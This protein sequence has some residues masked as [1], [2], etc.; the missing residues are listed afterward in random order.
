MF[1]LALF[2]LLPAAVLSD[3]CYPQ[4][5]YESDGYDY[6]SCDQEF[7]TCVP[8]TWLTYASCVYTG[9]ADPTGA[10]YCDDYNME[11][12]DYDWDTGYPVCHEPMHDGSDWS[13]WSDIA[14]NSWGWE[15]NTDWAEV[16]EDWDSA[17]KAG[18]GIVYTIIIVI[19]V[20]IVVSILLCILCC[21]CCGKGCCG[22]RR[23]RHQN[24]VI[25]NTVQPTDGGAQPPAVVP[26]VV[27]AAYP[28]TAQYGGGGVY[29]NQAE[30][31]VSV[32]QPYPPAPPQPQQHPVP[33]SYNQQPPAYPAKQ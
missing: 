8:G 26:S 27:P 4:Y 16:Q 29:F 10:I 23:N 19:V 22:K 15:D 3:W 13:D 12:C 11:A 6:I 25:Q 24:V 1:S 18:L 21:Y 28:A 17:V 31:G 32:G 30:G 20:I 14:W 9:W 5:C 33:M 7:N 2:L